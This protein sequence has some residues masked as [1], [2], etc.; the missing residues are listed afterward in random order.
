MTFAPG[1]APPTEHRLFKTLGPVKGRTFVV[2]DLHGC[3]VAL[4]RA[5]AAVSFDT[6]CDRLIAT[7][8]LIDRGPFPLECLRLLREPWFHSV[9]GNHD[10]MVLSFLGR[11]TKLRTKLQARLYS[12]DWLKGLHAQTLAELHELVPH[13]ESLPLALAVQ[14]SATDTF[15]V[16]HA[17]RFRAG[18]FITDAEIQDEAVLGRSIE[19]LT[20]GRRLSGELFREMARP[21]MHTA[22]DT[23]GL[24]VVARERQPG[25]SLTYVGHTIVPYPILYRSHVFIDGGAYRPHLKEAAAGTLFLMEHVP[26]A[27]PK[28][29]YPPC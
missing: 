27:T 20:W 10:R 21:E 6:R 16:V 4:Q 17:E 14:T 25:V 22:Y 11:P 28:L 29:A 19:A 23:N 2:G 7:G 9:R 12:G 26:G 8:D 15:Y 3:Y 1:S 5:L 24:S 13:V 18:R